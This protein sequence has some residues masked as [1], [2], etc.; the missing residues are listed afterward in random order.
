MIITFMRVRTVGFFDVE[1]K[2]R[3]ATPTTIENRR[4]PAVFLSQPGVR[5]Y[6]IDTKKGRLVT[7]RGTS[8]TRWYERRGVPPRKQVNK[9]YMLTPRF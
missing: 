9:G 8:Q 5:P 7:V 1:K 3:G 2:N 4:P 6:R